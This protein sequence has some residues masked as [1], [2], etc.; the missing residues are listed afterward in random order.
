MDKSGSWNVALPQERS[1]SHRD[2]KRSLRTRKRW[3]SMSTVSERGGMIASRATIVDLSKQA[4]PEARS[5]IA[6]LAR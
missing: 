1:V 2:A 6:E 3:F 4:E 5:N